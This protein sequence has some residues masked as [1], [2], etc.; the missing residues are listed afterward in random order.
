MEA[1]AIRSATEADF[2]RSGDHVVIT[3]GLTLKTA[4]V[5]NVM[6]LA[7]IDEQATVAR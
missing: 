4:G 2:V 7:R 3:A 5:T 6:H 1:A